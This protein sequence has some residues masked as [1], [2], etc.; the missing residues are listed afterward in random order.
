MWAKGGCGSASM[1]HINARFPGTS[2]ALHTTMPGSSTRQPPIQA[3]R[4]GNSQST[5]STHYVKYRDTNAA[6]HLSPAYWVQLMPDITS[7]EPVLYS[8]SFPRCFHYGLH[9]FGQGTSGCSCKTQYRTRKQSGLLHQSSNSDCHAFCHN[10]D[11]KVSAAAGQT[12]SMCSRLC[13]AVW[14]T[15]TKATAGDCW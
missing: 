1:Q 13:P 3:F 12:G 15:N 2:S 9:G 14:E 6:I 10:L 8:Q 5:G 4:E 7:H 11:P